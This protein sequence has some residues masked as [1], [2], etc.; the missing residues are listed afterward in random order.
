MLALASISALPRTAAVGA[1]NAEG[2]TT[3][4]IPAIVTMSGI[5]PVNLYARAGRRV[6]APVI[7]GGPEVDLVAGC[8]ATL[9]DISTLRKSVPERRPRVECRLG[10]A[11]LAS[12]GPRATNLAVELCDKRV[13]LADPLLDWEAVT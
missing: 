3:G 13:A 1:T 11:Q 10:C 4:V 7:E 9:G 5:T 8:V 2:S 6:A 12:P